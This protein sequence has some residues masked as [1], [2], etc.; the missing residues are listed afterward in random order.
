MTV[1]GCRGA[2]KQPYP[3]Y[4]PI[5][6]RNRLGD[7]RR[8]QETRFFWFQRTIISVQDD[9]L[10]Y[11]QCLPNRT[12][13]VILTESIHHLRELTFNIA[14]VLYLSGCSLSNN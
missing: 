13:P 12:D 3:V 14:P 11:V 10:T 4:S 5:L 1:R 7:R 2:R 8:T 6:P 9:L